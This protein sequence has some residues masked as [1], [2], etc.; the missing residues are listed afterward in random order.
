MKISGIRI[1]NQATPVTT[2]NQPSGEHKSIAFVDPFDSQPIE[3]D[4]DPSVCGLPKRLIIVITRNGGDPR[5]GFITDRGKFNELFLKKTGNGVNFAGRNTFNLS[6]ILPVALEEKDSNY[7]R[8]I[9]NIARTVGM[10]IP[11]ETDVPAV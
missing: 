10:T 11:G 2:A 8:G 3:L 6:G 1:L 7:R 9:V 4:V 5:E